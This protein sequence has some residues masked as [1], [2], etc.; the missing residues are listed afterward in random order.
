MVAMLGALRADL[1]AARVPCVLDASDP[2]L[3]RLLGLPPM[4]YPLIW[5]LTHADLHTVPRI[6]AF[7]EFISI[8]LRKKRSVFAGGEDG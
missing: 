4:P 6:A 2:S 5:V 1:G 8:A 3:V 7:T